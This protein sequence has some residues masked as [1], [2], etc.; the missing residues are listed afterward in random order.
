M[1]FADQAPGQVA[2]SLFIDSIAAA[3][4][5]LRAAPTSY[6]PVIRGTTNPT[7]FNADAASCWYSVQGYVCTFHA[8]FTVTTGFTAGTGVYTVDLPVQAQAGIQQN[9]VTILAQTPAVLL[10]RGVG[11]I[12]V[13][14]SK[15]DRGYFVDGSGGTLGPTVPFTWAVGA[16]LTVDGTY[17][18]A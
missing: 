2:A 4:D 15:V 11:R 8:Q 6:V 17:L 3:V 1:P 18:I 9:G 13:G 12:F 14:S 5:L 7:N 10:H 16:T